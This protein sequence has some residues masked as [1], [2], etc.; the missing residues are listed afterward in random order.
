MKHEYEH[1]NNIPIMK[2][3][4]EKYVDML[5]YFEGH[6]EDMKEDDDFYGEFINKVVDLM[7]ID[8]EILWGDYPMTEDTFYLLLFIYLWDKLGF[9]IDEWL[10]MIR[11]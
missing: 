2:E 8:L 3:R 7:G 1:T 4:T 10:E 9:D 11:S 5:L 6:H